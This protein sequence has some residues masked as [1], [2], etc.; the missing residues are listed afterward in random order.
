[1]THYDPIDASARAHWARLSP[2][3]QRLLMFLRGVAIFLMFQAVLNWATII[4]LG[5]GS[6]SFFET[7]P[8]AAQWAVI[9]GAIV[10]PVAA[11]GLWLRANWA[12]IFWMVA[13]F[14]QLV[15][16]IWAPVGAMLLG[17]TLVELALVVAYAVLYVCVSRETK[18]G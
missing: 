12:V 11:V 16:A 6:P 14:T 17:A 3:R 18:E 4:G 1:M 7:L 8:V 5:S 9:W 13:I 2:W 15:L 10:S